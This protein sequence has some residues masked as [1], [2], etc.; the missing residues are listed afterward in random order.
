MSL[1]TLCTLKS[2]KPCSI[3]VPFS[4]RL[5]FQVFF[6]HLQNDRLYLKIFSLF[7]NSESFLQISSELESHYY[8]KPTRAELPIGRPEVLSLHKEQLRTPNST[9]SACPRFYDPV[10]AT[11][12]LLCNKVSMCSKNQTVV[13]FFD[14]VLKRAHTFFIDVRWGKKKDKKQTGEGIGSRLKRQ[15]DEKR[16]AYI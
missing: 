6:L 4:S 5:N 9:V 16:Q 2:V 15:K 10:I 8:V 1:P 13:L 12:S 3:S 11:P 7:L 14:R